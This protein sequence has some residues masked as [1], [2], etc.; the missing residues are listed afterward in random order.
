MARAIVLVVLVISLT[1]CAAQV[2]GDDWQAARANA[3]RARA[4]AEWARTHQVEAETAAAAREAATREQ[5]RTISIVVALVIGLGVLAGSG[6]S[7]VMWAW[8]RAR[9]V[10]AD[11][12]GLYP[13]VVGSMPATNLNEPGAQSLRIAP[14]RQHYQVLPPE[15]TEI[16]PA[17][18]API[19][20]DA[21]QLQHIERLLLPAPEG[22]DHD[23]A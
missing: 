13:V 17:I 5:A 14:T 7:M 12:D 3:E 16:L 9:L 19:E 15:E 20:L 10:F 21:R 4:A 8:M 18:P 6:A 22:V 23:D 11:K 2:M 1:S